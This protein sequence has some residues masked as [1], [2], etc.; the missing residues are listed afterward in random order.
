MSGDFQGEIM[1]ISLDLQSPLGKGVFR[2]WQYPSG[3][4]IHTMNNILEIKTRGT[5][6]SSQ[7][8]KSKALL[9]FKDISK[10]WCKVAVKT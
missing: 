2:I 9:L 7:D 3:L 8:N 6:L 4:W 10:H 1:I 5:S